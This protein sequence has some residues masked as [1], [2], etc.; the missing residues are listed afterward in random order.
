MRGRE[1][2]EAR[3]GVAE[4]LASEVSRILKLPVK[5]IGPH[6]P[7]A[8]LGMDSLMGLELR[9][10]IERRFGEELPLPAISDSTTLASIASAIVARVQ[11]P[12]LGTDRGNGSRDADAELARRHVTDELTVDELAEFSEAL[13]SRRPEV[14][15]I[16]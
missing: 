1:P 9:L 2:Q 5:E 12:N 6:R 15:R 13:R 8:E 3:D 14:E 10:G 11:D 7:L 16:L 4:I